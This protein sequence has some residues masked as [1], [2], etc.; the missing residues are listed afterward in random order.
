MAKKKR[1]YFV[2]GLFVTLAFLLAAVTVIWVNVANYFESGDTYVTYF[3]ESVQGISRGTEVRF[4][5]VRVG[6]V[7]EVTIAPDNKTV[8]VYMLINLRDELPKKVV[9]QLRMTGITGLMF[10]NL[11]PR[12]PGEPDLSP[13]IRFATEY[14]VIP[15]RPS[16]ITQILTSLKEVVD[17]I[18][19]ADIGETVREIKAAAAA[20]KNLT[21]G[22]ELKK[23]LATL[24]VAAG[25]L[26]NAL[27]R[28]DKSLADGKLDGVL[29]E[30]RQAFKGAAALM[31]SLKDEV[32]AAKIPDTVK[33]ARLTLDEARTVMANLRR[34][35]ETLD[36]V[37]DR[38]N[39]R[40][41]DVLFGKAPQPRF[42]EASPKARQANR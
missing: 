19:Q 40:P 27:R 32:N 5:G 17:N 28:I 24:D 21:Q 31:N 1:R 6:R 18:K 13:P 4:Q 29:A 30:A 12:R 36:Q 11:E 2:V 33:K 35:A 38:L 16:D 41:A 39:R 22:A 20:I 25:H 37:L 7:T 9:A 34:T 8:A 23:V 3:D 15:S 14:P 10:V 26:Q 42:N